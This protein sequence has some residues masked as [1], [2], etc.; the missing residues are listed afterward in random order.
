M[1]AKE[2][3]VARAK[4][5]K[6]TV[7]AIG[8]QARAI[9]VWDTQLPGFKVKVT[10]AGRR[11][12]YLFY[13]TTAGRKRN[14]KI[15]D[16][17]ALTTEQARAIA[18]QWL[19]EAKK[20]GDPGGNRQAHRKAPTVADLA[21]RYLEEYAV[22][23]KKPS[24][25]ASDRS[26][27]DNHVLPL[28]GRMKIR[29]VTRADI[30][31]V[32]L[33]IRSGKTARAEKTKPRGRRVVTGGEGAANRTIALLS[34]M[35]G[36]AEEWGW[37]EGNPARNIKKYRERSKDRYLNAE[38]LARLHAALDSVE[39]DASVSSMATAALR[40]LLYT[41][42]RLG[43]ITTLRWRA[44][45]LDEGV[46]RLEDSK[47]GRK[48]IHLGAAA[49]TVLAGLSRGAPND[50]V[51]LSAK[52]GASISLGKPFYRVRERAGLS[53]DVTIHTLR[54]TFASWAVMG[55][56]TLAQTG[57]MLGHRSP[58]TTAKYAH[59]DRHPLQQA[60]DRVSAALAATARP[61]DGA[62]VVDLPRF[63]RRSARSE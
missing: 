54:H 56:F 61:A 45:D 37:R 13:R 33:A 9:E 17:G 43:E 27:I 55:G 60:A 1:A 8:S 31:Q 23:H 62:E 44:V 49:A 18:L 5:T 7:E 2:D 35:F 11:S 14:P 46:L 38:E 39:S 48:D 21:T 16:H 59:H 42:A 57:A 10:P 29:D 28:L 36:L 4:L 32:K 51:I 34:K 22:Q 30:D 50:L 47:T 26:N 25:I 12:Y 19:A 53:S 15:G 41:G 58:I 20:G 24:S 6:R 3:T 52:H 40:L 63:G